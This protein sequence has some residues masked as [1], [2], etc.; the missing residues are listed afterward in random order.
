MYKL[1]ISIKK[2]HF[3][4]QLHL[5]ENSHFGLLQSLEPHLYDLAALL[6]VVSV[7]L[8]QAPDIVH[9]LFL[10][11]CHP[12]THDPLPLLQ[13]GVKMVKLFAH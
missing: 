11:G 10:F 12:L 8:R 2:M 5:K 7:F 1:G 3:V 6:Q 13:D 9:L 4:H